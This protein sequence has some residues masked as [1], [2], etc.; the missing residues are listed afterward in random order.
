MRVF[1]LNIFELSSLLIILEINLQGWFS[2]F[3]KPVN[4]K[5]SKFIINFSKMNIRI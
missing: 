4:Y 3:I 5:I 2:L 1:K